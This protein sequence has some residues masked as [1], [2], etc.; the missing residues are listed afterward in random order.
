M[1]KPGASG[2]SEGVSGTECLNFGV[3]SQDCGS[4]HFSQQIK[5]ARFIVA[6]GKPESSL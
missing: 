5:A 4:Y 2:I 6:T 1:V 3:S